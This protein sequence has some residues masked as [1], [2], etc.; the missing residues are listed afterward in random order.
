M[1]LEA[2]RDY[3]RLLA[4]VQL[5]PRLRGKLDPS[6]VVQETLARAHEKQH[7]FR[8]TTEV[9][10][11][12]WLRQILANEL[13]AAVRRFHAGKRDAGREQSLQAAVE[14][15]SARLEALLAAEQTSPSER[16]LRQ[17]ELRRLAAALAALPEDQRRAV[18]LHHLHGLSVED[19]AA[20][21]SRGEAAVGGLLR[22]GLKRLRELMREP[23]GDGHAP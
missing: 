18:E 21:L 2:Y 3:L 13:A 22:R 20:A 15:S 8:G 1:S 19:T 5:G 9:E 23:T 10:R 17:E 14:Q 16:V 12:A 11:A 7:Q 4:G 6:D